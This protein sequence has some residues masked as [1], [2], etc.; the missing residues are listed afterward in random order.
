MKILV[1]TQYFW[2]ENFRINELCE[3]FIKLGHDVTVL[4]GLPNYPKGEIYYEFKQ[5][6]NKFNRYKNVKVIRVP[7]YPRGKNKLNL[8]INYLSFLVNSIFLGYFKIK[9][10]KFDIV[11]T[12]QLSPVTV[13]IT[14]IFFSFINKC[15]N[16]LWVLDLWPDTLVALNIINKIWQ[17]KLSKLL[18][19][20]IYSNCDLI[21]AQSMSILYEIKKNESIKENVYFLPS[22]GEFDFFK[23]KSKPAREVK[24]KD[25]F[26]LLFAG[27]IGEAQDFPSILK[28]VETLRTQNINNF[29]LIL[30]GDGSKKEW[31]KKEIK[32]LKIDQYFE[33]HKSYPL[34]RMPS[35]FEHADALL[36]SLL[37]R[38]VFNITIPGK[39]QF[40]LSSGIP[41]IGMICGEGAEIIKKSKAGLICNSG[42]HIG[43][44]KIITKFINLNKND[45]KEMGSNG[46]KYASEEFLK[47]KIINKLNKMLVDLSKN[48]ASN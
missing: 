42:D 4:T 32:K 35:F 9:E 45:L 30:I 29:R 40:Y 31:L 20:W 41:I 22:W 2:P 13:G 25:I 15:P 24:H 39:V 43:F 28:A 7:I 10:K 26:T 47:E 36:I 17:I 48:N 14:S 34:E 3:E 44:S 46:K 33:L 38:D 1:V 19:N 27:N 37:D 8:A 18:V 12:F 6:K 16:V 21:L 23:K 5:N 11:F